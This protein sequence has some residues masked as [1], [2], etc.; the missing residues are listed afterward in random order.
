MRGAPVDASPSGARSR[1]G[2][3]GAR[4]HI[5]REGPQ[6]RR[7]AGA[8]TLA[9]LGATARPQRRKGPRWRAGQWRGAAAS[10]A[11][12]CVVFFFC[13]VK[14]S[15]LPVLYPAV[16]THPITIDSNP[17]DVRIGGDGVFRTGGDDLC[18]SSEPAVTG[19]LDLTDIL[20]TG[21]TGKFAFAG[22]EITFYVRMKENERV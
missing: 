18:W 11:G 19:F 3:Y 17:T 4:G 12:C 14:R 1:S 13:L 22:T 16:M 5:R 21:S 10:K 9:A 6:R 7:A 15:S 20:L 2:D 8:R